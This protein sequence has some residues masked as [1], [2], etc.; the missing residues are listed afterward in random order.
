LAPEAPL[1]IWETLIGQKFSADNAYFYPAT[2]LELFSTWGVAYWLAPESERRT[3]VASL[4]AAA[5]KAIR[6]LREPF[7]ESRN[8]DRWRKAADTILL[9]SVRVAAI[10]HASTWAG[11]GL[12]AT[13]LANDLADWIEDEELTQSAIGELKQVAAQTVEAIR[14]GKA[15]ALSASDH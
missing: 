10:L 2:D 1:A 8:Y 9:T 14:A 15:N 13:T 11:L 5:V 7:L 6:V 12:D 3:A 4:R